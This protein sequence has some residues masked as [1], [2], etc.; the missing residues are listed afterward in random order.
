MRRAAAALIGGVLLAAA[1]SS[2]GSSAPQ[3]VPFPVRVQNF[4]QA[5]YPHGVPYDEAKALGPAAEPLL[6]QYFDQ[7]GMEASRSNIIVTLGILG[8]APSVQKVIDT[9]ELGTGP[10]SALEVGVRMDA[11]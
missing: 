10:L 2:G 7:Q 3:P 11:V 1:C 5:V 4:V 8:S 9:I 6:L